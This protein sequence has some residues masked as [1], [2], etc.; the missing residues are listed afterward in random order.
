MP[1][2]STRLHLATALHGRVEVG[3]WR[4]ASRTANRRGSSPG[5]AGRGH[6]TL[7][8][9]PRRAQPQHTTIFTRSPLAFSPEA[10]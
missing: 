9:Q 5:G 8:V 2:V 7:T 1:R 6:G 3:R 4:G 10:L